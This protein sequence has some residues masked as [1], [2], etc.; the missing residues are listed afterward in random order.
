[1]ISQKF[2][3]NKSFDVS[4]IKWDS[5][6]PDKLTELQSEVIKMNTVIEYASLPAALDRKSVV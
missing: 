5:Y 3:L 6:Q 2:Y 1:M 4:K